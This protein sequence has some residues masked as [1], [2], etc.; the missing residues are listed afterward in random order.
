MPEEADRTAGPKRRPACGRTQ[1]QPPTMSAPRLMSGTPGGVR[2][3]PCLHLDSC[4]APPA[5]FAP[6]HACTSTHVRHPRR[7]SPPPMPAPRLMSGTPGGVRP[8]PCLHLDSCPAP[9]A[10]FA[11][12]HACTSTHVRHPRRGSPPT[13]PAPRL[14]SGTP[15]GVR[16]RPC[17]HLDSCPAPPAGFAPAHACTSTH[18]RHPRRGSPPPMPAPRLMS[19]TP[20]GV[21]PRPC[22]HLDSCPAPPAGFAP[23][24]ACTSTHVR[25]PRRGSPPTMPAP[26]LMSGTPGGVRP[27][28]CLHLDSCP[29]PPAGFAPAH[30]C[31]STHVRHPRRGSP[32]PMPAPRL[33]SGTPGG[34][35][36]RPCLHLDSCPAPPAGFA[37]A[38]A[39]TSTHVRHPRRGSP[40]PMPAPRLMSG[41]PGG[42][43]PRPCLHL[44]SCP[45]P[46]AGFAPDHARTSTH[47][48]HPTEPAPDRAPSREAPPVLPPN[49]LHTPPP[50]PTPQP[51]PR[52]PRTPAPPLPAPSPPP[53]LPPP[54]QNLRR[55]PH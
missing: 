1:R 54:R 24:H 37:P 41:T 46:P 29:A 15:G 53:S 5:G 40:P 52:P 14:M 9:P 32:P 55:P 38:H 18:V 28:P 25:H 16:P 51:A 47:A 44:D 3:R 22:L 21:R 31:T 43:R 20:G 42:V 8:R 48:R 19:G 39:C 36:P 49:P 35:R 33:M 45:A 27:R 30:A 13:M 4:P 7:G 10:G 12:A 6:A 17:L 2:P 34:V 11:P 23:A 26:R 50:A